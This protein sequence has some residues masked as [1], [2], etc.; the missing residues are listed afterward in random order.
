MLKNGS[1]EKDWSDI[2]VG[3]TN[4]QQPNDWD[5]QWLE[6]GERLYG[7]DDKASAVPE[8]VHKHRGRLVPHYPKSSGG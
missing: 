8:C 7:S 3:N 6:P 4:N 5:L 1:F 2:P